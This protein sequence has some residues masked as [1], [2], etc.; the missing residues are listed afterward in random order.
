MNVF[1]KIIKWIVGLL[2]IFSGAVKTIDPIGFSLK[3]DEYFTIFNMPVLTEYSLEL[4]VFLTIFE[5]LLGVLLILGIKKVFTLVSLI[6]MMIFFTFLTFYSAYF[7]VVQDCGCFG[8]AI[9][10]SPWGSF[11]KDVI[12]LIL[13]IILWSGRKYIDLFFARPIGTYV[14]IVSVL[15]MGYIA[16][17]GIYHLPIKDFRPYAVGKNIPEGMKTAEELGL[18][19]PQY[20]IRYNLRNNLNGQKIQLSESEYIGNKSY[21]QKGTS[22]DLIDTEEKLINK[23]YEPP[24]HDFNIE[25]SDNGDMTYYYLDLPQLVL[26]IT[27]IPS[28][29]TI[30]GMNKVSEFAENVQQLDIPILSV[31]SDNVV[32]GNLET[33][34]MDA[35]TLKTMM[36]GNPGIMFLQSGT[37]KAK[38]HWR[39]APKS[40][41]IQKI[42][43]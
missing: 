8:D 12:L 26:I 39:D 43:E 10:L 41:E 15:I 34:L 22:W 30:K 27:P 19:P 40:D 17:M 3:L 38:Y 21:W 16:F 1:I 6:L 25:C 32:I 28:E 33:C 7:E 31:A 29:T 14:S 23:G 18:E 35:T 13:L 36:R 24:I 5:V 11:A 2:F 9:K 4:S 37:I 20:E 42:F